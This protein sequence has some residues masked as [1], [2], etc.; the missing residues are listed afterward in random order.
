ME[1]I[2]HTTVLDP[3]L[4]YLGTVYAKALL[5]ASEKAGNTEAVLAEL[6]SL[7]RDVLDQLPQLEATLA[8]PRVAW[9]I[10]EQLLDRAFRG[11]MTPQTLTFLKVLIRRGRFDGVRAVYLAAK[12]LFNEIRGKVEVCL[13]TAE[14]LDAATRNLIVAK[15]ESSLGRNVDL[16]SDVNADLI[17]G[18]VIRIG[19]TVYDGSLA[20]QLDRLR[21]KLVARATQTLRSDADRFAVAN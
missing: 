19:D 21:D 14:P 4:R 6:D 16:Q 15:L 9:E 13:T 2:R 1:Q 10:K 11:T 20:D 17:G 18:L 12:R 7:I 5:G 3:N 8:S